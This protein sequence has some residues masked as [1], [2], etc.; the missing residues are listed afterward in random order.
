MKYQQNLV[1]I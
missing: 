1:K